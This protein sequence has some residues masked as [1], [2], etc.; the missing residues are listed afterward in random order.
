PCRTGEPLPS[1]ADVR[2]VHERGTLSLPVKERGVGR[3]SEAALT[4]LLAQHEEAILLG[5][6]QRAEQDAVHNAEDCGVGPDGERQG[7]D[8]GRREPGTP[9]E[10]PPPLPA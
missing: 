5:E 6:G 8:R 3:R 1:A 10:G 2:E 7:Q 9:A 4:A